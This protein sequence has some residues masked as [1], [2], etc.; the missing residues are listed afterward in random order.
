M[1]HALD[2]PRSSGGNISTWLEH[3][4][5]AKKLW[6]EI[7]EKRDYLFWKQPDIRRLLLQSWRLEAAKQD[8]AKGEDSLEGVH[9]TLRR[10]MS[11][12]FIITSIGLIDRH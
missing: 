4:L 10:Y 7:P 2:Q 12:A 3:A 5:G 8:F 11:P 6:K 9:A 1:L